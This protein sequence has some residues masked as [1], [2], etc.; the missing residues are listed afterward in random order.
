MVCGV[1]SGLADHEGRANDVCVKLPTGGAGIYCYH[2]YLLGAAH[3][4]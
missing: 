3:H 4:R 1:V 2:T